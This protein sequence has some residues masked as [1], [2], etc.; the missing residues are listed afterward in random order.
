[1]L[2][3][4]PLPASLGLAIRMRLEKGSGRT[5]HITVLTWAA[6]HWAARGSLQDKVRKVWGTILNGIRATPHSQR[7]RKVRGPLSGLLHCLAKQGWHPISPDLWLDEAGAMWLTLDSSSV[8][9]K[10]CAPG[11][12]YVR[13]TITK[14]LKK[15][16][17]MLEKL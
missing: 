1:M 16:Y 2:Q 14:R 4:P 3:P 6:P 12:R 8:P 10:G 11:D 5:V 7:W 9:Q 13:K 17:K 15:H